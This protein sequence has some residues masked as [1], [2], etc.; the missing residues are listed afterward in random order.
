MRMQIANDNFNKVHYFQYDNQFSRVTV[1]NKQEPMIFNDK[2]ELF[3]DWLNAE[4]L[5][6]F[7]D[8]L[9]N[10]FNIYLIKL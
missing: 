10:E 7:D 5:K 6:I 1:G 4:E 2:K 8:E 3:K 9:K